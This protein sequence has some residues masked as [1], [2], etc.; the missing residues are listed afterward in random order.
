MKKKDLLGMMSFAD[1]KYVKEADPDSAA[2]KHKKSRFKVGLIA[3][4]V[5]CA[6]VA[7]ALYLFLPFSVTE[8]LKQVDISKYADS[9]YYELIQK[10]NT[11]SLSI[12]SIYADGNIKNNFDR[13]MSGIKYGNLIDEVLGDSKFEVDEPLYAAPPS[14]DENESY[15]E[16]TDN[17]TAGVT[18]GDLIKRSDKYIYYLSRNMLSVYSIKGEEST[19]I[20]YYNIYENNENYLRYYVEQCEMYLSE[21]CKT[22]III[23]PY[24][25]ENDNTVNTGI[26]ALDVS[27]PYDI[28]EKSFVSVAGYYRLSRVKDGNILLITSYRPSL[29]KIDFDNE[30]TFIPQ[31]D[32]GKGEES[33]PADSIISPD[34][35]T[36][37]CYTV[38]TMLDETS[39][40]VKDSAAY[41]SYLDDIYVSNSNIYVTRQYIENTDETSKTMT[42]INYICYAEDKLENKGS[43]SI[44]GYLKD[45][46][47][48]DEY[49]GILRAVTTTRKYGYRKVITSANLYC[50]SLE[51]NSIIAQVVAFAPI[52]ETVRSV[53]FDGDAAYVCTAVVVTDPVFFFDLSDLNNITY[54]DT[55][56]ISGFSSS[57]INL[58]NGY[59]LG[60]GVGDMSG[61]LKI[62][63]YEET[64]DGVQSVCKYETKETVGYSSD[65]KSYYIDREN[66]MVGLGLNTYGKNGTEEEYLLV[67]FD[68]YSLRELV[69]T[70]LA[71]D[72]EYKRAVYIDG[73]VYMFGTDD[74]KVIKVFPN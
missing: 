16:I 12:N 58:K 71:G 56:N 41:I 5:S 31:I 2:K 59:L 25:L 3:A 11:Y 7:C 28:K 13:I 10:M 21:D 46:Y 67:M 18:E 60:I 29:N 69:K 72:P 34:E 27:N 50:I 24:Y 70:S 6:D 48:L 9:E 53:R 47:S 36:S 73:Y 32:C 66:N 44:E 33:I 22:V 30:K 54:K 40:D 23:A 51:D 26:I 35:L 37:T 19:R 62:E 45:R 65:Y 61:T 15:V 38:I 4:C 20:G 8:K 52:G 14:Y 63:V 49:N 17:Q 64:A 39:L 57:L 74:F 1:E 68:G 42:E 43:F 55:G